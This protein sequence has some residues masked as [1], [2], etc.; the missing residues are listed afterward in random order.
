MLLLGAR[1]A[2]QSGI[3]RVYFRHAVTRRK[4]DGEAA[5]FFH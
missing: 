1:V 2:L 3:L 5:V 4:L